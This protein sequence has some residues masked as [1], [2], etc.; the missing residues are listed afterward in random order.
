MGFQETLFRLDLCALCGDRYPMPVDFP[1]C[2]PELQVCKNCVL[3]ALSLIS[4]G[5]HYRAKNH[6][7]K[8]LRRNRKKRR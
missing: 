7:R 4:P 6:S 3:F 5:K 2:P 8:T 1:L